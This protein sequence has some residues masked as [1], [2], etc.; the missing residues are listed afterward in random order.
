V[1]RF[2]RVVLGYHGCDA[3]FADSLLSGETKIQDWQESR[4]RYDWLGHG[5]YFW[6]HGPERAAIWAAGNR[7]KGV[8]GAVIQLGT[9]LD[10]TDIKYTAVLK[11]FHEDLKEAYAAAGKTLPTNK[12][13]HR[14]LDCLVINELIRQTDIGFQT[15]RSP[16]LEGSPVFPGSG[17][18]EES[19]IQIT[20]IDKS[21]ILGVFRPNFEPSEA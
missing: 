12:Q 13:G 9:C 4:N 11:N 20:V 6:E 3:D 19:H 8:I 16:F 14:A 15:V 18:L 5:V 10:F 17:I 21:C 1:D 2:A 7:K